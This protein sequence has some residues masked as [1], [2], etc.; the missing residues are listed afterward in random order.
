MSGFTAW[1]LRHLTDEDAIGEFARMA[2]ADPDWP[3]GPDR[4]QTFT[5][6]LESSGATRAALQNLTDAWVRYASR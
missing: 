5:R 6:H 4:L 1:L 3:R 2:A